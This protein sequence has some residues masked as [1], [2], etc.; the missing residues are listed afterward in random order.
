MS[1]YKTTAASILGAPLPNAAPR[2]AARSALLA[3]AVSGVLYAVPPAALAAD[4]NVLEEVVVTAN[5]RV[6][7]VQAVPTSI[8]VVTGG[9]LEKKGARDFE[10]YL[11]S[12][13]GVGMT[14]SGSGSVKVGVRG[15]SNV[16]GGESGV[17]DST[18]TVGL[19]LNDVPIQGSGPLPDLAVYDLQRVEVLKGPQGTLYG[20]G[21]MGGA[22][23]MILNSPDPTAYEAKAETGVETV[24]D[25]GTNFLVNGAVN[26]PL[27]DDKLAAR[28]V[29]TYRDDGGFIDNIRTGKEDINS[30]N[31]LSVRGLLGWQIT[32]KF[33][34]EVLALHQELDQDEFAEQVTR[35]GDLKTDLI[36]QRFNKVD[37]DLYAL[38]LKYDFGGAELVSSTSSWTNDRTRYDRS[39]FTGDTLNFFLS[40]YDSPPAVES[41]DAQGFD[42]IIDQ[43]AFTQELRLSSTGDQR[44]DWSVGAF[45]RSSEQNSTGYDVVQDIAPVNAV[46]V[47]NIVP[48]LGP[49]APFE[50]PRLFG[51]QIDEE[52]DQTAIFGEVKWTIVDRL[53]LTVGVRWFDE[54]LNLKQVDT[55]YDFYALAFADFGI[56]N[57]DTRDLKASD[58]DVIGR[59]GLS[60]QLTPDAMIYAM[61]S[62]GFRSG[63]PNFNGGIPGSPLPTLYK[64]DSL[65]N[66]EIGTKTAWLD[67]RLL[68]NLAL[69]R[70]DWSDVQVR[71]QQPGLPPYIA[72]A[73]EA[74]ITGGELQIAAAPTA[75]VRLGLNLGILDSE[76]TDLGEFA[77]GRVG[78]P[79]PNAPETTASV[80]LEFR[81]PMGSW[82]SGLARIDWQYVDEQVFELIPESGDPDDYF[83]P[84]YDTVRLQFGLENERWSAYL[85]AEN[86]L[87]ER[88]FT[89][90]VRL[91][92]PT[93]WEERLSVIRPR[94]IGLRFGVN[95]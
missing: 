59:A 50:S 88:A 91:D 17:A 63:G 1:A 46:I 39:G 64:S 51:S 93:S 13:S 62:Q 22:I 65:V 8:Q 43:K 40:I 95:F 3:V 11:S 78:Q 66:Y 85:Y 2:R 79:L 55:A 12:V 80:Y 74:K 87:D 16:I 42:T 34:A 41:T 14:K 27:V 56:P 4:E 90:E 49:G 71:A 72:N 44:V 92:P 70:V 30:S 57:P 61:V 47:A 73:G 28:I 84:A 35:A 24:A 54:D 48:I 45:Y 9:D 81:R 36:D 18:S 86:L 31:A 82:G 69:Y 7:N 10:S 52:F 60:Y 67:E 58:S 23:K 32:E 5:R 15:V 20:E 53:D 6:E 26:L 75:G 89:N 25:G 37:F 19:Y 94:T 38:T 21:A 83:L 77:S 29:A 33:S 68:A 76:M